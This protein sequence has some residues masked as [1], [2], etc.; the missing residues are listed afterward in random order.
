[1]CGGTGAGA[2]AAT[3]GR[4]L[5]PRVRGNRPAACRETGGGRVYPRVCGGTALR[6]G[7][8]HWSVGLSPRVRGNPIAS[9]VFIPE[10]RSIPAC[11]GEP[12]TGL[13]TGLRGEVYPRV[14]GGTQ[15]RW[16]M[17][18]I[19]A[20]LSPRV[21]GNPTVINTIGG[22][23]G[24]IPACA[25]EPSRYPAPVFGAGVYPRVCGGT[26]RQSGVRRFRW[27][28]SP[29]V[30]GNPLHIWQRERSARSIPAC[31]GEPS[32]GNTG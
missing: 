15:R 12:L 5:S 21:R 22:R 14:C 19:G 3:A 20:G 29:R 4:G 8:R 7:T 25:G 28:L 27:G 30:R 6:R 23:G 26:L 9:P 16:G 2:G 11:A 10:H 24:S 13:P 32:K 17:P 1:M 18:P 31:A